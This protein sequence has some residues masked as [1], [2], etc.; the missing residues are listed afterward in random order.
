MLDSG[1]EYYGNV[2]Y[3]KGG[4]NYADFVTTVSP[5]YADEIKYPFTVTSTG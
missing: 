1:F 4:I 5:T 2:N 3:M